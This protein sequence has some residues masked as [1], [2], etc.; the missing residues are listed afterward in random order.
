MIETDVRHGKSKLCNRGI[1][2]H[3]DYIG[4]FDQYYDE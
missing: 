3:P 4:L 2:A 1:I